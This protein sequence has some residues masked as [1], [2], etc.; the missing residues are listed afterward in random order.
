MTNDREL[1]DRVLKAL[2][3][4]PGVDAAQIGVTAHDGVVTLR[5][6]VTTFY[7]KASAERVATHVFGV[8]AIANDIEVKP[9]SD[10]K[11]SD[12]SIAE[13]VAN[14]L[15]WDCAVP[16]KA[17]QAAVRDGWVTL[18]GNVEWRYQRDA[19]ESTVRRLYGIKGVTNSIVL[20]PHVHTA[21]VRAK[22]EGAF[23]RSAEIDAKRI[24]VEAHDGQVILT[25]SVRSLSER[26]EAER[27][28]WS[29]PGV[30]LVD[31]RIAVTP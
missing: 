21:D 12:T 26:R 3:F 8:R 4:E 24:H 22:I 30:T 23:K 5:G 16:A 13:A 11:R 31:D 6:S 27:A 20:K 2:E 14:A 7:Q 25:G 10:L 17:V 9:T 15:S 18:T 29:A 28:A 19:A 1:Q